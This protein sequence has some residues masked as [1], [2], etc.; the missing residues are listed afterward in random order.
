MASVSDRHDCVLSATVTFSPH[1]QM[2]NGRQFET[3][4]PGDCA[5]RMASRLI[6]FSTD[7]T[8]VVFR[9]RKKGTRTEN[10]TWWESNHSHHER[11]TETPTTTL[12]NLKVVRC[13]I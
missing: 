10:R 5:D 11:E 2:N 1:K 7:Y 4:D 12:H 13:Y 8:E 3:D 6:H 9:C